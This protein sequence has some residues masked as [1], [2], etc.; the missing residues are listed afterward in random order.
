MGATGEIDAVPNPKVFATLF[1]SLASPPRNYL[2]VRASALALYAPVFFAADHSKVARTQR[3][4]E[5]EAKVMVPFRQA[6][7]ARIRRELRNCAIRH[8]DGTNHM[9]IGVKNPEQV[10]EFIRVFLLEGLGKSPI[11]ARK[12]TH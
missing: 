9:S 10:A 4:T 12:R 1:E 11:S 5:W 8:I 7:I 3:V 6:S 2:K